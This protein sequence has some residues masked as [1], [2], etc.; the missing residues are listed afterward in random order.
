MASSLPGPF[1]TPGFISN[2]PFCEGIKLALLGK[3]LGGTENWSFEYIQESVGESLKEFRKEF[4][5][6]PSSFYMSRVTPEIYPH[7]PFKSFKDLSKNKWQ[8]EGNVEKGLSAQWLMDIAFGSLFPELTEQMCKH[9]SED[10]AKL[11]GAA[12]YGEWLPEH[13]NLPSLELGLEAREEVVLAITKMFTQEYFPELLEP[14]G[15]VP[16]EVID[17]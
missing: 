2:R 6:E 4:G 16:I 11:Y 9:A 3:L 14:L 8:F 12:A 5:G 15:V 17:R 7:G 10:I 13:L 1:R